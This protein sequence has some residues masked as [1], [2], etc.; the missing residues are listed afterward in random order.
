MT[1]PADLL[2]FSRMHRVRPHWRGL[3]LARDALG[4]TS[5]EL[6]HAGPPMRDPLNVCT[7]VINSIVS[8]ILFEG[9]ATCEEDAL[10]L[11]RQGEIHLRPAQDLGCVVPLADVL[12]P[13]MWVQQ[14]SDAAGLGLD[15]FSPLNAGMVHPQRVGVF[16]SQVVDHLRWLNSQMA[17]TLQA[18][19]KSTQPEGMDL[20]R[21][22]DQALMR[23]D[24]LHANNAQASAI[25]FELL[26]PAL[27]ADRDVKVRDFLGNAAPFFLNLW[28]AACSCMLSAAQKIQDCAIVTAAGGN[29]Q[30]FGIQL[31]ATSPRW[32]IAPSTAPT[33]LEAPAQGVPLPAIGDSAVVDLAGF[34][35]MTTLLKPARPIPFAPLW[36]DKA[37]VPSVL[38][39]SSHPLLPQTHARCGIS[40][41]TVTASGQS[42]IVALGILDS[43]GQLGRIGGGFF[44]SPLSV[45]E[46]A[47]ADLKR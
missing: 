12:S 7:P 9:W 22:A 24:D 14:V 36:P 45:F 39:G 3:H 40:A 17:A 27:R 38:L 13:S 11:Y 18:A 31:G 19:L 10:S 16:N 5:K 20:M 34:G 32:W 46:E 26:E 30:H 25:L 37:H 28:M 42:P 47:L 15:R 4:M 21:V 23:G 35:S 43:G 29:G 33:P 6:L 41:R 44:S 2:G 1:H 8:A